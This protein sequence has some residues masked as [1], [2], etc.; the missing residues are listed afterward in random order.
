MT[1]EV[2]GGWLGT[3]FRPF[4][5]ASG[6]VAVLLV[7]AWLLVFHGGHEPTPL[8]DPV[9]WH[10]HEMLFG[11]TTAVIAG[12]FLT[13][14]PNWCDSQPVSG[15]PLLGLLGLWG[16]GRV[17]LLVAGELP[18]GLP[19]ILDVAFLPAMA[20]TL[21]PALLRA[22]KL[23]NLAFVPLLLVMAGCNL[24]MHLEALELLEGG[25]YRASMVMLDLVVLLMLV[26]GGR[27]IPYFTR[28]AL[29]VEI[30]EPPWVW[31]LGHVAMVGVVL[32]EALGGPAPLLGGLSLLAAALGARRWVSWQFRETWRQPILWVLSLG[33]AWVLA[34]LVAKAAVGLGPGIHPRVPVHLFTVGGIGTLT[35]GMMSRVALGHTGRPLVVGRPMVGAYLLLTAAAMVRGLGPVLLPA[36]YVEE[37]FLSGGLW[38]LAF[39]LFLG[40]YAPILVSPRPDGK[41]G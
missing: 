38:T 16:A 3:G 6:L 32:V 20:L 12:F 22:R 29:S 8:F 26:I 31:V 25:G 4:F 1:S 14:V 40:V 41:P 17:A 13:A 10:R 23:P 7:P 21:L 28:R 30:Q 9:A 34:G 24:V 36:R 18:R 19:A 5:L 37:L 15:G 35:L 2:R 27:V 33:Y 39:A 11:Y